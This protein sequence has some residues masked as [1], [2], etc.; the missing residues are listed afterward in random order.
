MSMFWFFSDT[1]ANWLSFSCDNQSYDF[2]NNHGNRFLSKIPRPI[3][4]HSSKKTLVAQV[5]AFYVET[6][7][8]S[9]NFSSLGQ[10][11]VVGGPYIN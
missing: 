3:F 7:S 9:L 11:R 1:L 5:F 8:C 6:R 10:K 2:E 4:F